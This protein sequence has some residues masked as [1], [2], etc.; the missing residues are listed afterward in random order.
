MRLVKSDNSRSKMTSYSARQYPVLETPFEGT[1]DA[2]GYWD[3]SNDN[4]Y[5]CYDCFTNF[6]RN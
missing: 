3:L 1:C 4:S 6:I 5:D 2:N